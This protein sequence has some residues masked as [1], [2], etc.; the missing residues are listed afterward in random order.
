MNNTKRG[1]G[2]V[3]LIHNYKNDEFLVYSNQKTALRYLKENKTVNI[4]EWYEL[5]G[6]PFLITAIVNDESKSPWEYLKIAKE[7]NNWNTRIQY[8]ERIFDE[9][10]SK[11]S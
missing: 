7:Q 9:E 1:V 2:K 10:I 4:W 3:I 5:W 6:T 11:R 8:E